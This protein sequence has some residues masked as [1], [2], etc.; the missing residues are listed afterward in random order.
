MAR[1]LRPVDADFVRSAPVR[2]DF[3]REVAAPLAEDVS[4]WAEWFSAVTPAGPTD[5]GAGRQIRLRGGSRFRGTILVAKSPGV[6]AYRVDETNVPG[7]RALVQER[8]LAPAGDGTRV[9][10]TFTADGTPVF[11]A[12][13]RLARPGT[14]GPSGTR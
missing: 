12:V 10:R 7:A 3:A 9:Q 1:R 4:G 6:Y 14:G 5:A 8:R 11:R 2:L 13:L